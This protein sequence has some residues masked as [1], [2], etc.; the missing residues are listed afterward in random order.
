MLPQRYL[1]AVMLAILWGVPF[2]FK[3]T[4]PRQKAITKDLTARAGIVLQG[5]ARIIVWIMPARYVPTWRIWIGILLSLIGILTVQRALRHLDKQWRLDAALSADHQLIRTGPYAVLR[6]PIYSAMFA[7]VL[8]TGLMLAQWPAI[9]AAAVLHIAGTEIRIRSEEKLLR[10]RFGE[11]Y[12]T[13]A[14]HV[15]AYIP[16]IR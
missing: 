1:I 9:I 15:W 10:S 12:D 8:G 3:Y 14:K 6:H 16:F 7:M 5:L 11:E 13:W 4:V 2:L